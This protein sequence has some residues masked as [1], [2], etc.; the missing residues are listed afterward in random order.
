VLDIE[1]TENLL[2]AEAKSEF[3]EVIAVDIPLMPMHEVEMYMI[4]KALEHTQGHQKEAAKLLQISDRTIRNKIGRS[5]GN[6]SG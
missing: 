3:T 6:G 5:P 1:H 4:K 2:F